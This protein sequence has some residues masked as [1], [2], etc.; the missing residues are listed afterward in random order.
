MT[1]RF[2][3]WLTQHRGRVG[4]VACSLF[5]DSVRCV[6]A[7]IV[8]PAYLLAYQGLMLLVR[9]AILAGSAPAGFTP[10]EWETKQRGVRNENRWDETV[11]DLIQQT[12]HGAKAAPLYMPDDVRKQFAFWRIHRNIC[13]HY[14]SDPFIVSHVLTLYEFIMAWGLRISVEGGMARMLDDLREHYDP[15]RTSPDAPL[16]PLIDA[17]PTYV[18]PEEAD[19]FLREATKMIARQPRGEFMDFIDALL[20]HTG[21]TLD[22]IKAAIYQ[23]AQKS[24]DLR[25]MLVSRRP[26]YILRI[27]TDAKDIRTFWHDELNRMDVETRFA[28]LCHLVEAGKVADCDKAEV[29]GLTQ[30]RLYKYD[31]EIPVQDAP[32]Q[33]V[34]VQ[35][36]YFSLF[37]RKYMAADMVNS[38][39]LFSELCH[40]TNFYISH[41]AQ[42]PL[43][44]DTAATIIE[45]LGSTKN[46]PYTLQSRF[47]V[48]LLG[49]PSYRAA[50]EKAV[51]EGGLT[52]PTGWKTE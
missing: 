49:R 43:D 6:K 42:T 28:T 15:S 1:S 27:L 52:M 33:D 20:Q 12:P 13:A 22:Y 8:R 26:D 21:T 3:S 36:G 50:F 30:D 2:E 9:K 16:A 48:E 19:E 38:P 37:M 40:K 45:A 23:K 34:L 46:A 11:Y 25:A 29:C 41:L 14:K 24:A 51:V 47:K 10:A 31:D 18:R 39:S 32:V 7:D 4:D 44:S 17:I 35:M 5:T